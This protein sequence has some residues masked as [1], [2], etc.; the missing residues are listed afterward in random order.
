M[1]RRQRKRIE[2]VMRKGKTALVTD[3]PP[4]SGTPQTAPQGQS[5]P[6]PISRKFLR[7]MWEAVAAVGVLATIIACAYQFRPRVTLSI[8]ERLDPDDALSA[9]I[10]IANDGLLP[11][12]DVQLDCI[13]GTVKY[14]NG[15]SLT[16]QSGGSLHNEG[17]EA[18][19]IG[20]GQKFATPFLCHTPL[21]RSPAS[22]DIVATVSFR[23]LRRGHADFR[24]V[25]IRDSYGHMAAAERPL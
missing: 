11:L 3:L 21:G 7:R 24:I 9:Q 25:S 6:P 19:R 1:N 17:N 5:T 4:P 16:V 13:S 14:T 2:H 23:L 18:R 12:Y 22:F 8:G 20:P 15:G 10:I